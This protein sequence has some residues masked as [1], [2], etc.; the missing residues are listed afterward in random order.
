MKAETELN[1]SSVSNCIDIHGEVSSLSI[2][3]KRDNNNISDER[4]QSMLFGKQKAAHYIK[5]VI[6]SMITF[7]PRC[8]QL[9]RTTRRSRKYYLMYCF[10]SQ[11][12]YDMV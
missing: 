12:N 1:F 5:V 10:T 4:V 8:C 11:M 6:I 9:L 2:P 3:M 7:A